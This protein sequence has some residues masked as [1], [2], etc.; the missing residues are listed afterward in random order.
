[1]NTVWQIIQ[2]RGGLRPGMSVSIKNEPWMRL[3]IEV[4]TEPGPDGHIVVSVAHYGEQN[5]DLMRDPE[6][7]FEVVETSGSV[8]FQPFY[9]R[10][11]YVGVEEWSRHRDESG[12]PTGNPRLTRELEA[13]AAI[14]DRNLKEQ[15][16]LRA[17]K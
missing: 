3:A 9:F 13:F 12:T 4:L 17:C 14:W 8:S 10:N 2:E 15:G 1:V 11:D 7:L 5:G 6:M 16:F